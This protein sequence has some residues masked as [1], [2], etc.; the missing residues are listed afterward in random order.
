MEVFCPFNYYELDCPEDVH[1][2]WL[3]L[4]EA[5]LV[6]KEMFRELESVQIMA[7]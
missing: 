6:A 7:E 4:N 2:S 5:L 1:S 3:P